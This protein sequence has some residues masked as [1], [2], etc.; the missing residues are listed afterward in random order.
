MKTKMM[1]IKMTI[2]TLCLG[3]IALISYSN[4]SGISLSGN[5]SVKHKDSLEVMD[6][7]FKDLLDND[8]HISDFKGKVVLIDLWYSGCG[9]CIKSNQAIN[10]IHKQL[11][12]ENIVFL[13]I[14]VDKNKLKWMQSLTKNAAKS[15]LNPWAGKYYSSP[16]TVTLYCGETGSNNDFVKLYNPENAYPSLLLIDTNGKL[17]SKDP[18]RPEIDREKLI[19]LIKALLK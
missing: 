19:R 13:S 12:G 11:I 3:F 6:Y 10:S 5:D 8:V 1:K 16:G 2:C 4:P 14:S 17:V 18:P 9:A 15:E 7:T